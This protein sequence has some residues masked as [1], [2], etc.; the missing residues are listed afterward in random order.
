MEKERFILIGKKQNN[1]WSMNI[2]QYGLQILKFRSLVCF[3]KAEQFMSYK[4]MYV[5]IFL[6]NN[7]KKNLGIIMT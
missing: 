5:Q 4:K 7:K 6:Y 1:Y 3:P 2:C